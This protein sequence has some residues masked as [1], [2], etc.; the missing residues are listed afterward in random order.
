[1]DALTDPPTVVS[2]SGASVKDS[3]RLKRGFAQARPRRSH[4]QHGEAPIIIHTGNGARG[5]FL[6]PCSPSLPFRRSSDSWRVCITEGET[7]E[8]GLAFIARQM[9]PSW[10]STGCPENATEIHGR[11]SKQPEKRIRSS[12]EV[13]ASVT[14]F[15]RKKKLASWAHV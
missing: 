13:A 3:G 5:S 6:S 12:D 15:A 7:A 14:E 1:M 8:G 9:I 2:S 4:A 10:Q 11:W